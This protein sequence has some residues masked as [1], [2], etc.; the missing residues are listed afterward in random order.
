MIVTPY[1]I[2]SRDITAEDLKPL[3]V[4][5]STN[6]GAGTTP[7]L[8]SPTAPPP[9]PLGAGQ[10]GQP[11]PPAGVTP[12]GAAAP[13]TTSAP[14]S[15]R[16]PGVV[17][18]VDPNAPVSK[19]DP[20]VGQIT[21][22]APDSGMQIGGPPYT[23]P[24]RI[25]GV[26]QVGQVTLTVTYDPKILRATV[27]SPGAF[28]QQGGVQATFIPKID[29]AVGRIDVAI[30]R[31]ATVPGASGADWLAGIVFQAVGEGQAR[32]AITA[33]VMSASG[34]PIPVQ[35]GPVTVVVKK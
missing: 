28:M 13:P 14:P 15:T 23:M 11:P 2:R 12:P 16:A 25:S 30:A 3:Y 35:T 6:L 18:V 17:P 9:P 5:T 27:V 31:P 34:Q 21:L 19:P 8:I 22:A 4:G 32:I 10:P 26:S 20:T 33:V 29:D 1:V 7:S 24:V